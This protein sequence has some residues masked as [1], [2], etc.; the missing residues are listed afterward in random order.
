MLPQ[1][2]TV[3]HHQSILLEAGFLASHRGWSGAG[4]HRTPTFLCGL[5]LNLLHEEG[6]LLLPRMHIGTVLSVRKLLHFL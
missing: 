5:I 6:L 1:D 2:L 4:Q 3:L